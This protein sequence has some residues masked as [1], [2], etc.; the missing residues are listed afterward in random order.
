MLLL[1]F[2]S[3]EMLT[4]REYVFPAVVNIDPSTKIIKTGQLAKVDGDKGNVKYYSF[5]F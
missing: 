4:A 5:S 1:F 3:P 2:T